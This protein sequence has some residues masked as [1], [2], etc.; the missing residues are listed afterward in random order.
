MT[1]IEMAAVDFA[2]REPGALPRVA[3]KLRDVAVM[4]RR[5]L[6]HVARDPMVRCGALGQLSGLPRNADA[7]RGGDRLV[8]SGE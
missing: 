5:N 4:T 7:G 8:V 1:T 3:T 6:V 2:T